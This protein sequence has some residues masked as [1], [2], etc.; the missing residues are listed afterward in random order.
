MTVE[1][2]RDRVVAM[3]AG[4]KPLDLDLIIMELDG[5][6]A[7]REKANFIRSLKDER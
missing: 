2:L 6:I 7:A 5:I 3:K 1:Q 4:D